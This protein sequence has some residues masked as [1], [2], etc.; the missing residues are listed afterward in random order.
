MSSLARIRAR[1]WP[2]LR[3]GI[4][5]LLAGITAWL[6]IRQVDWTAL[7]SA[8]AHPHWLL[9]ALALG[10]VLATTAAKA[11]RWRVLLRPCHAQVSGGRIVRVLFI[12]QMLNTLLP[13]LGDV[14]RAVLL[15]PQVTGGVPAVLGTL[16][17]EKAMD[18]AIG[19]LLLVGLAL[20]TPLPAW[21]RGPMLALAALTG[22]LLLLLILA[23]AHRGWAIRL[24]RRAST[25]LPPGTQDRAGRLLADFSL[26]LGLLQQP[27]NAVWALAWSALVWGLGASTNILTLAALGIEAPAWSTWLVLITGYVATFL[28]T[29]PVQVGIF[30]YACILALGAAGVNQESALAFGLILHFLVYAPPAVLGPLSM[31]VEGLSWTGLKQARRE[32]LERNHVHS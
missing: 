13:R 21:L 12:G 8:L 24:Y 25:W 19:L 3:W 5:L 28:P 26:G 16:L 30:E 14:A 10:T 32:Y 2:G 23:A 7:Q 18:G 15:G 27:A 31:A 17:V 11:A 4:A 22:G 29:V 9:L 6:S 1:L 20:W